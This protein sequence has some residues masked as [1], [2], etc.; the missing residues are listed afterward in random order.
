MYNYSFYLKKKKNCSLGSIQN[1]ISKGV[2][3]KY[4]SRCTL[5]MWLQVNS[6][7][8]CAFLSRVFS[9][10]RKLITIGLC[11]LQPRFYKCGY[12]PGPIASFLETRLQ[13][14][15]QLHLLKVAIGDSNSHILK[16]R[17]QP[18]FFSWPD[19][20]CL[21]VNE[22]INMKNCLEIEPQINM[23]VSLCVCLV[24]L[25]LQTSR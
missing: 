10:G 21:E 23:C 19:G 25:V 6:A 13:G 11:G 14:I 2:S 12:R 4:M 7:Y 3:T 1:K 9:C 17:L 18:F 5:Q 16:M 8:S 15:F 20:K 22:K 24:S